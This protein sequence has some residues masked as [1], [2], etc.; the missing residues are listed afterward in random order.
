MSEEELRLPRLNEL[1]PEVRK[2][3]PFHLLWVMELS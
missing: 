2:R 1:N 3:L